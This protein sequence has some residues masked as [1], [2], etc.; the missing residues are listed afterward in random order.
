MILIGA[1]FDD[2]YGS[3]KSWKF[4]IWSSRIPLFH[5]S[6]T[7]SAISFWLFSSFSSSS[8]SASSSSSSSCFSSSISL[9]ERRCGSTCRWPPSGTRT[10]RWSCSSAPLKISPSSS[11]Q[12]R[13]RPPKVSSL[14]L[15]PLSISLFLSLSLSL[16]PLSLAL[17]LLP[18]RSLFLC[19]LL[20]KRLYRALFEM[21]VSIN[22]P[23]IPLFLGSE[24]ED[25]TG[26]LA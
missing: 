9:Q 12:S 22:S 19:L 20:S 26:R 8:S 7:P 10:T 13:T 16:P 14:S 2:P 3:Q 17:S 4:S 18:F 21:P 6:F 24:R 11:S 23:L 5:F 1:A 25:D 15:S